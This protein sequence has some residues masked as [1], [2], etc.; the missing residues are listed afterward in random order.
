LAELLTRLPFRAAGEDGDG[1]RQVGRF[2]RLGGVLLLAGRDRLA[3]VFD[4]GIRGN[5]ER[6]IPSSSHH[7][8]IADNDVRAEVGTV[9]QS[10]G[11][12]AFDGKGF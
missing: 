10:A 6:G 7:G 2:D 11:Q 3:S 5:A 8:D 12:R 1:R 9:P 4:P